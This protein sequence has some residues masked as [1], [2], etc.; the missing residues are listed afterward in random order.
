MGWISARSVFESIDAAQSTHPMAIVEALE[1]WSAPVG[2]ASCRYRRF[3]HQMLLQNLAVTVKDKITDKWNYFDIKATLPQ[4]AA[5][6]NAV[7]GT[8]AATG[9]QMG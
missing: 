3:D 7:F 5:D 4:D 8:E 1:A 6:M 2:H 9:C